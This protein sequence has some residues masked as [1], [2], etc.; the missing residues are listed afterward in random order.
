MVIKK[1][2][3]NFSVCQLKDISAVDMNNSE[4]FFLGKTDEELSL[5][6]S[7]ASVPT[8]VIKREDG[9]KAFRIE[10]TLDFSLIGIL[11]KIASLLAD[12]NISIFA[13][14]TFNTDYVLTRTDNY[15]RALDLL[16]RAGYQII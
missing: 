9:W 5:V 10:G 13:I 12:N 1:I 4:F 7:T 14:S 3:C 2:D 15:A 6:C 11:S 8:S 16:E